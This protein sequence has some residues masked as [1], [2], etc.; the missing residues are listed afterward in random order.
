MAEEQQNR[1][2]LAQPVRDRRKG[3]GQQRVRFGV[4][5]RADPAE[6]GQRGLQLFRGERV[7]RRSQRERHARS[8]RR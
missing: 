4:A 1:V 2:G 5:Y 6:P 8:V 7:G 3:A